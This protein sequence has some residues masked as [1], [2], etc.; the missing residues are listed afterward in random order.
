EHI[1]P[2]KPLDLMVDTISAPHDINR[3][4]ETLKRDG[5]MVLLGVPPKAPTVDPDK[6]IMKR[7]TLA[8]S[9]IGGLPE[10]QE[11]LNF[12]SD[13]KI[14]PDIELIPVTKINDA[15][16]RMMKGDVRYRF[17]IDMKTLS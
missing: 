16:E 17:V 7:R 5:A 4:L 6:L 2:A 14:L 11:M 3:Y 12:C 8:G 15:Y 1:T 9:V 13:K 10:T